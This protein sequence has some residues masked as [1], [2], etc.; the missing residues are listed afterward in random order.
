MPLA[1]T[2]DLVAPAFHT[3]PE[4]SSSAGAEAVDFAL[5][6]GFTPDPEQRLVLEAMYA[7]QAPGA[8]FQTRDARWAALEV[9]IVAAR[10]NLK[11]AVLEM[12]VA[13]DLW[14]FDAQ[15]C[16]WTAHL[17]PTAVESF[18]NFQRMIEA[19]AH[20]SRRVKKITE[21]SGAQGVELMNGARLKFLARSRSGGRGLSGDVV[22]LDE[23]F[24]LSGEEMGSLLPTLSARPNPQV[25]YGSSAGRM[26]SYL[27]RSVRD[28]GRA[29]DA[30]LAWLEWCSTQECR[31]DR[32][33]HQPGEPGC[34][35]D[36]PEAWRQ[37][38]P[39]LDRRIPR[40]YIAAE[41]R[42]LPANEFMRERLGRWDEP[43][44]GQVIPL[45]RWASNVIR[46]EETGTIDGPI[47]VFVD[48]ALDRSASVIAVSGA[49]RDGTAQVEIADMAPGTDWVTDRV[50]SIVDRNTVLSVGARSA[51]PVASLLPELAGV[52]TAAE[53]EFVKVGSS[54]FAGMCGQLYDAAMASTLAHRDDPRVRAALTAAKRHQVLDAWTWERTSV[55][56]DAA[57]LVAITGA[58]SLFLRHQWAVE[59]DPL[60]NIW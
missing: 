40:D 28:R 15:L 37:A 45:G 2:A 38:N 59:S 5:S 22:V 53:V 33:S 35:G 8:S 34:A 39:Q 46:D 57:P 30:S 36:D 3:V 41:R 50:A 27:L 42:S 25:R 60:S 6:C 18:R 7:E 11:T 1:P 17:F 58:H 51:G 19:N 52:S 20:L 14:L 10:Q 13:A 23:A 49:N 54:D 43:T 21:G 55:D 48:V 9:G 44:A 29:G 32:C 16:V 31:S 12:S 56:V 47:C 26:D 24:A 4:H